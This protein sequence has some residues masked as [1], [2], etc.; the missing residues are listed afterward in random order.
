MPR[1]Q[2][3]GLSLAEWLVL[4][5]VSEEP[6]HGFALAAI[7]APDGSVGMVW[8]VQKAVVYRAVQR[9][10]RLGLITAEDKEHSRHGPPRA[11]L[12]VTPEGRRATQGWLRQPAGH[13][14]DVRPEL[15]LKLALLSRLGA[16][17]RDLLLAQ[18]RELLPVAAR[19]AG[20]LRTATGFDQAL[21][22]WRHESVGGTLRFIDT[23]L[24]TAPAPRAET[25]SGHSGDQVQDA[26]R[27]QVLL[28]DPH[29]ER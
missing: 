4:G 23:L 14:R 28:V 3:P 16:D 20:Q 17:P 12:H 11:R 19:L 24:A 13:H 10:E 29:A 7:L 1:R 21:T 27:R 26:G 15:M 9:L 25:R 5:M 6:A 8:S 18:R 22:R 2:G